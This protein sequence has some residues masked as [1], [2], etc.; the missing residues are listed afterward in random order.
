[1]IIEYPKNILNSF[2]KLNEFEY[3]QILIQNTQSLKFEF[4]PMDG[5]TRLQY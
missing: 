2:C 4:L 3:Y 1:M 5:L